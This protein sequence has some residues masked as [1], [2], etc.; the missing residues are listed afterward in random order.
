M[1]QSLPAPESFPRR[2]APRA[3]LAPSPPPAGVQGKWRSPHFLESALALALCVLASG[4]LAQTRPGAAGPRNADHILV[5]VNSELVTAGELA[6]RIERVREDAARAK[7]A[8]P[9]PAELRKQLLDVLIDER[10]QITN[11]REN[12]PR[13]DEAEIDRAAANVAQQN[14]LTLAQLRER[15]RSEGMDYA[16]F[17]SSLRDQLATERMR[18][19]EMQSRIRITDAEI[20]KLIAERAAAGG[21]QLELNIA[22]ILVSLPE[23]ASAAVDAERKARAE[24]ALAR[25]K[26]GQSFEAVAAEVSE[27]ANKAAGGVL[28]LRPAERLPDVF[29]AAVRGLEAGQVTP[30][31]LRTG[32]GFHILKLVEKRAAS[33]FAVAQTRARHILLRPSAQLTPEAAARRLADF[34]RQIQ[35]GAKT[36]EALARENSEDASAAQ[37]GELGWVGPGNFV[38]EFEEAMNALAPNGLSEPVV[39]R[40]GLH[41][42][43]VLERRQVTLDAR[44]QREQARNILREQK[45]DQ[46]YL[47]WVRELRGR[48]YVEM[49]EPPI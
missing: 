28:G 31:V 42:I 8:L 17:R 43:Q 37:G 11:A 5:V 34:K 2:R 1:N 29:V 22:Q 27:D 19:R 4:A 47:E 15:L 40:F 12:G 35:S 36:F 6:Q 10:V 24:A 46:A 3:G 44:Q 23:G 32:A 14:Q 25:I 39:S 20:D 21:G 38:P 33:P 26:V 30:A 18:E 48:A 9:P 45:F 16:R 49:R 7:A 13:I 41:L